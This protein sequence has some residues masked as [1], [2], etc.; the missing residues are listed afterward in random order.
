MSKKEKEKMATFG[1]AKAKTLEDWEWLKD[2]ISERVS[3]GVISET[4]HNG[5]VVK[6]HQE[7]IN[8]VNKIEF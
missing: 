8:L 2:Q 6:H 1:S 4:D 5:S 3:N 7:L